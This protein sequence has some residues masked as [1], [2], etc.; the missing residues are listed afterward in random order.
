M[1]LRETEM[2]A[3]LRKFSGNEDSLKKYMELVLYKEFATPTAYQARGNLRRIAIV[4]TTYCNLKCVWCHR[5]EETIKNAGYL[6]REMDYHKIKKLI[7]TLKGFQTLAWGGLGEPMMYSK[8]FEVTKLARQYIPVVKTTSNG[9][10]LPPKKSWIEVT[11]K[12][13]AFQSQVA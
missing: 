8:F 7:P 3:F 2:S 4:L 1:T 10:T 11:G 6:H 13:L 12:I 5:E 9:T